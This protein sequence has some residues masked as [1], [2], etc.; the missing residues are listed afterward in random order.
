MMRRLHCL[1][2]TLRQVVKR[3][4]TCDCRRP[5]RAAGSG[6]RVGADEAARLPKLRL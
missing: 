1:L 4:Q 6:S 3:A 5:P 2:T